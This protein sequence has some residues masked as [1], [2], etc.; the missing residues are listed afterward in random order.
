MSTNIQ[1]VPET[2]DWSLASDEEI[3]LGYEAMAADEEREAEALEWS[4]AL[5]GDGFAT[6]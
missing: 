5:I 6:R 1:V 4:E 3:R 2:R